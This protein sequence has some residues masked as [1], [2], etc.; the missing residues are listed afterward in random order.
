[1]QAMVMEVFLEADSPGA[2]Q[3]ANRA[4]EASAWRRVIGMEA[5]CGLPD[6]DASFTIE[7]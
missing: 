7:I 3:M 2:R 6:K 5:V 4:A 1:M